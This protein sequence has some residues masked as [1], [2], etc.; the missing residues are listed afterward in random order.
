MKKMTDIVERLRMV[1]RYMPTF[2]AE[3]AADEIERLQAQVTEAFE[4][5]KMRSGVVLSEENDR[6]IAEIERL[7]GALQAIHAH[8]LMGHDDAADGFIKICGLVR[9]ALNMGK[10][11][12]P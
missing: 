11:D 12:K 2:L 4:D 10:Q 7:R 5:A 6:L 9:D 3:E 8:A 1:K